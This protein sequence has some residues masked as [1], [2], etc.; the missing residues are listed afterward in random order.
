VNLTV[1]QLSHPDAESIVLWKYEGEYSVYNADHSQ[2]TLS[3]DYIL[4]PKNGFF[5]V[6]HDA[7]LIGF[8]SVSQDGRVPGGSYDDSAVDLGAGMRPDLTGR[9]GGLQFLSAITDF[10]KSTAGQ[11]G[12]R[13]TIAT[14]NQRAI[15]T[16]QRVGFSCHSRFAH[17]DGREFLILVRPA[18]E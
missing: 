6:Y 18:G 9:G 17:P 10:A 8:C 3:T 4:D 11:L 7:E 15:R 2:L 5:G 14:W 16:A 12:L 13:A 1:R